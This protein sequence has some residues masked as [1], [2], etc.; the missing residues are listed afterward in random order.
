M[1]LY[2]DKQSVL[3]YREKWDL[4]PMLFL[5]MFMFLLCTAANNNSCACV[6]VTVCLYHYLRLSPNSKLQPQTFFFF[7]FWPHG[8]VPVLYALFLSLLRFFYFFIYN[9]YW[10]K[11]SEVG[12]VVGHSIL[13]WLFWIWLGA[14]YSSLLSLSLILFPLRIKLTL[15][16]SMVFVCFYKNK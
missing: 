1:V 3:L 6:S 2:K 9:Y 10:P 12:R 15:F 14:P 16:L 13:K 11:Q 7:F 4:N 8:A 5:I